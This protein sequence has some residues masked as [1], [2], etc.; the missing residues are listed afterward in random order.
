MKAKLRLAEQEYRCECC[1]MVVD[2][3]VNA[4]R[5]LAVL[6]AS[7][8][9]RVA[10]SGPETRNARGGERV[11]PVGGMVLDETGSR[12]QVT[13]AWMRPAPPTANGRL[14]ESSRTLR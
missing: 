8:A 5:N 10:G 11:L 6:V 14:P 9:N 1:G 12:H 3:D 7:S 2:R 4:A 13:G